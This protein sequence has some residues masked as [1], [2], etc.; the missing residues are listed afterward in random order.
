[1]IFASDLLQVDDPLEAEMLGASF[2]AVGQASGVDVEETV[3]TGFVP[4]LEARG[5]TEALAMLLA[6]ASVTPSGSDKAVRAAVRRLLDAGVAPPPWASELDEP[7]TASDCLR[8]RDPGGAGSMLVCSFHR[9]GRT[10]ATVTSVDDLDCGAAEQILLFDT[11]QLP[12]VLESIHADARANGFE[13]ATESLDPADFRWH[14]EKAL[15]ARAVHDA[16]DDVDEEPD[17]DEGPPYEAV[18]VLLKAR[19]SA[20]PAPTR[21]APPHG[22]EDSRH[23]AFDALEAMAEVAPL[24]GRP[25]S[26]A[27]PAGRTKSAGSAPVYQIK[28]SLRGARPPIWRRLEVPADIGLAKLHRVIQ[29][30]FDWDDSHMHVFETPYGSF[31]IADRELGHRAEAPVTLEQI[32]P[33]AKSK[34]TYTYD[35]GDN[36]EHEIVVEKVLERD[37][38]AV[39]PRCTGGRKAAPPDDCGGLWGY[40]D[41]VDVLTD[42][43]HPEHEERLEWLGLRDASEFDPDRF[44]ADPINETLSRLR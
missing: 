23:T 17:D 19:M 35:F 27:L 9:A 21:P 24:R 2:V 18:A 3:A 30:A 12:E 42:P 8:L 16:D 34:V 43:S 20:L 11:E 25:R 15:D 7:V 14:V 41:L 37:N 31:G 36:W 1:M 39:Y 33:A 4:M 13:V 40:A 10:H 32:A 38:A 44:N 5:G 22:E 29:V 28:V 26:T 6:I